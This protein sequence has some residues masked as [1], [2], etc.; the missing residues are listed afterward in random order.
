MRQ[1]LKQ[2]PGNRNPVHCAF[3]IQAGQQTSATWLVTDVVGAKTLAACDAHVDRIE[4]HGIHA[5]KP[6]PKGRRQPL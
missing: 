4:R 5:L 3:C 2:K 6:P 1:P